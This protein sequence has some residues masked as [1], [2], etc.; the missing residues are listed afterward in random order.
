MPKKHGAGRR[1]RQRLPESGRGL[2]QG[3]VA[4][5]GAGTGDQGT[6]DTCKNSAQELILE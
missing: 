3:T 6:G 5:R 4:T 2:R 1:L